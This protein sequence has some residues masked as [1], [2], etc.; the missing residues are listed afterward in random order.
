M[1]AIEWIERAQD[2]ILKELASSAYPCR[3]DLLE[4]AIKFLNEAKILIYEG[5]GIQAVHPGSED[6]KQSE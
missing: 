3:I 6:K 5:Q 2:R 1:T 4:E